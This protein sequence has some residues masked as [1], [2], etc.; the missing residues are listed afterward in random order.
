[1]KDGK[2]KEKEEVGRSHGWFEALTFQFH[3]I[4]GSPRKVRPREVLGGKPREIRRACY[5][6]FSK[7]PSGKMGPAP[8]R[9]ELSKGL[10]K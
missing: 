3:A 6:Q 1:M 8:G 7:V 10:L 4:Q 2:G 5:G 9:F